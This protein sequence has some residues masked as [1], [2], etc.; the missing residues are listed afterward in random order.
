MNCDFITGP[1][2]VHDQCE[3][4]NIWKWDDPLLGGAFEQYIGDDIDV[5]Q[6]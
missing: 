3:G 1:A 2:I 4:H 5:D 6:L